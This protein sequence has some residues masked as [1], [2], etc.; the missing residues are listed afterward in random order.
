[1][2][3][4]WQK[5]NKETSDLTDIKTNSYYTQKINF[6]ILQ[7]KAIFMSPPIDDNHKYL[8]HFHT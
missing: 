7:L 8:L 2:L 3:K 4:N 5:D 6:K 1:M